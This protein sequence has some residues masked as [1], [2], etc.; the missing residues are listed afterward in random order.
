MRQVVKRVLPPSVVDWLRRRL[1]PTPTSTARVVERDPGPAEEYIIGLETRLW[2]TG[3]DTEVEK[4]TRS[5]GLTPRGSRARARGSMA[6]ARWFFSQGRADTALR[7]LEGVHPPN[8]SIQNEIDLLRVDCHCELGH[9]QEALSYLSRMTGR[10]TREQNL[11][12]RVGHTRSLL[13][14]P[15]NHGSGPMIEALNTAF[16]DG[17]YRMI[18]RRSV[19]DAV[20]L[21]NIACDVPL[22]EPRESLPLVTVLVSLEDADPDP[23]GGISSL[24]NQSW[25]NLEILFVG[26]AEDRERL[27]AADESIFD[28]A[29]VVFVSGDA[30]DLW[31]AG[32]DH[33]SGD[34]VTGHI[35]GSWAHPQRIEAQAR[36]MM[37]DP[38]LQAT[39]TSH[40]RVAPDLTPR[41]LGLAPRPRLVGPNP[42]STMIRL[43]GGSSDEAV[44]AVRRVLSRLSP[45]SGELKPP[46][47]VVLISDDVPLTLTVSTSPSHIPRTVGPPG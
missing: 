4:L 16:A 3:R 8:P 25:R 24:L 36:A 40:L 2:S 12:L 39:V 20:G 26:G 13:D 34:M 10:G 42:N 17:G 31:R 22:A 6:L 5:V 41:P 7:R 18:R 45:L 47:N 15:R 9:A 23:Y 46:E 37:A 27:A 32:L 33:A 30:T 35:Y 19:N 29:R 14:L 11:L 38:M 1:R 44:A 43:A 21:G 28:D